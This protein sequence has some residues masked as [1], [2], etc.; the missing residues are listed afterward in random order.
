[1][2]KRNI[3]DE[4]A[5]AKRPW[6]RWDEGGPLPKIMD[7]RYRHIRKAHGAV[8][9]VFQ[10]MFRQPISGPRY[11][12]PHLTAEQR[13]LEREAM[14]RFVGARSPN[15]V[16]ARYYQEQSRRALLA[17]P[18]SDEAYRKKLLAEGPRCASDEEAEVLAVLSD[19]GLARHLPP[20]EPSGDA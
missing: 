11:A 1:M 2:Q 17:D 6:F 7:H 12:R 10:T 19:A 4:I 5:A 3:G 14:A 15:Q 18:G 16:F 9:Y 20:P 8:L 13:R